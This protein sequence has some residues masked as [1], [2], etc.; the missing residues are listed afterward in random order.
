MSPALISLRAER[1][2]ALTPDLSNP[3]NHVLV[4]TADG[5]IM[6]QSLPKNGCSIPGI[7]YPSLPHTKAVQAALTPE[8]INRGEAEEPFPEPSP[9][10]P[11]PGFLPT[12]RALGLLHRCVSCEEEWDATSHHPRTCKHLARRTVERCWSEP[13]LDRRVRNVG[14]FQPVFYQR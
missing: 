3:S 4:P 1:R 7:L 9:R 5:V 14:M 11:C 2:H 10:A 12:P 8:G 13:G 6:S